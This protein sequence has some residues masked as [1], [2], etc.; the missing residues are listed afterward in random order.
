M[1]KVLAAAAVALALMGAGGTAMAQEVPEGGTVTVIEEATCPGSVVPCPVFFFGGTGGIGD[2]TLSA[3][4][5]GRTADSTSFDLEA[6]VY[7]I[8]QLA[9]SNY[10]LDAIQ[11]TSDQRRITGQRSGI[12]IAINLRDGEN[13]TCVF[14]NVAAV[15]TPTLT[16][17]PTST[18]VPTATPVTPTAT[19][20]PVT[21]FVPVPVVQTVTVERVVEVPVIR[22]PNTGSGGLASWGDE[23]DGASL[24]DSWC[25]GW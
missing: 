1:F 3:T 8:A 13:I 9:N 11:C 24:F 22:P 6:G 7:W 15:P 21:V 23:N 19:A 17:V 16:P 20:T 25:P 5:P 4:R 18:P 2:F 10:P 14:S 12:T